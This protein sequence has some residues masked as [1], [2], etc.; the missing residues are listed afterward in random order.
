[1]I[2]AVT[3]LRLWKIFTSF[4]V[5]RKLPI[6]SQQHLKIVSS[7]VCHADYGTDKRGDNCKSKFYV[8]FSQNGISREMRDAG[9]GYGCIALLLW[10]T[11]E[12]V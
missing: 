11:H 9:E 4:S 7:S 3:L 5:K 1:M 10:G 12:T 8:G 2:S 6:L